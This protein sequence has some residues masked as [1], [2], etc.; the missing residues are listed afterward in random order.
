MMSLG[1]NEDVKAV[2][3]L[4]VAIEEIIKDL[5]LSLTLGALSTLL[6]SSYTTLQTFLVLSPAREAFVAD[7]SQVEFFKLQGLVSKIHDRL[8]QSHFAHV[9]SALAVVN[10]RA[11]VEMS[12]CCDDLTPAAGGG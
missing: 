6:H 1:I 4:V 5:P 2:N 3:A 8:K 9:A 12:S 7:T 11:A 10:M